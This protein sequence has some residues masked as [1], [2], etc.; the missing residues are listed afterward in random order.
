MRLFRMIFVAYRI[1]L[2]FTGLVFPCWYIDQLT[3][4]CASAAATSFRS[5]I[6]MFTGSSIL[7]YSLLSFMLDSS[8]RVRLHY[9]PA[10]FSS[11]VSILIYSIYMHIQN[12]LNNT[13]MTVIGTISLV[14]ILM[15]TLW[16]R[17]LG[18]RAEHVRN[19]ILTELN[20]IEHDVINMNEF[21]ELPDIPDDN[22]HKLRYAW[23]PKSRSP[24]PWYSS[25]ESSSEPG[26]ELDFVLPG[27]TLQQQLQ[28]R[29]QEMGITSY[30]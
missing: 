1:L 5:A 18:S 30:A 27:S 15:R 2:T 23:G 20:S 10:L 4:E 11:D 12:Q 28:S 25:S 22:E 21:P 19:D 9:I 3:G 6:I 17:Q 8:I 16:V 29:I 7:E 26:S 14:M 24:S 13:Q